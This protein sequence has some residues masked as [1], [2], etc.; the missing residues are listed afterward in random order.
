MSGHGLAVREGG[1]SSRVK[2]REKSV[3]KTLS[4]LKKPIRPW[5]RFADEDRDRRYS[6]Y[7]IERCFLAAQS[8]CMG[9]ECACIRAKQLRTAATARTAAAV[10]VQSLATVQAARRS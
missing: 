6:A 9:S 10:K 5:N 3:A 7:R 4:L 1:Q 2:T 8:R